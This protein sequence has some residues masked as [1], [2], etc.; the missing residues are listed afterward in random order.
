MKIKILRVVLVMGLLLS[1]MALPAFAAQYSAAPAR[2][3]PR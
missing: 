1:V 3:L 2:R